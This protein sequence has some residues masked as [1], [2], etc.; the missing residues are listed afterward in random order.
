MDYASATPMLKEVRKAMDKYWSESF[1]NPSAIYEEGTLVRREIE[2]YRKRIAEILGV[3][4]TDI[5]FTSGSTEA[6]NLA[7][8]GSFETA[9]DSLDKTPAIKNPHL[10]IS[11]DEHSSV[12]EVAREVVRRGGEV[13]FV[14]SDEEGKIT[15]EA[16]KK[17]IKPNTFMVSVMLANNE[18]GTI[19]PVSKIGRM[20]EVWRKD[21]GSKYPLFHTDASQAPNYLD[22]NLSRLHVD[23]VSLDGSKIYGPKGVGILATNSTNALRPIIFGGGQE[24][25]LRSGTESPALIAGFVTA[26]EIAHR[27]RARETER[28]AELRKVFI[29]ELEKNIPSIKI[30]GRE[31]FLPN[32][33]AV[34]LPEGVLNELVVLAFDQAGVAVSGGS[35]CSNVSG[36]GNESLLRFS[37]GRNSRICDVKKV[38]K[39]FPQIMQRVR[40]SS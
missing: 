32:I 6:N 21:E 33:V 5:I 36:G 9:R 31:P 22:V 34:E 20:I 3:K 24:K 37:F 28:L 30:L 4:K 2:E 38:I 39:L 16:I 15:S 19:L 23:S 25:G 14:E 17:L 26:L 35:S 13:S 40:I 1:E 12:R 27:D 18:T 10:I 29:S 11:S 8:L 7:I